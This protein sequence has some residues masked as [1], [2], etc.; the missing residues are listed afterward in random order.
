MSKLAHGAEYEHF[1]LAA[2]RRNADEIRRTGRNLSHYSQQIKELPEWDTEAEAAVKDAELS[3]T[4]ALLAVKL[5]NA[6]FKRRRVE[7]FGVAA[8]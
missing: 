5:V 1:L 4:E 8:E 6:E 7:F 2:C 3:L